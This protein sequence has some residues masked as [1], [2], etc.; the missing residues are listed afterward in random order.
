M[1]HT[2]RTRR[3]LTSCLVVGAFAL[4]A[5]S[6]DGSD[7]SARSESTDTS[8]WTAASDGTDRP[9]RTDAPDDTDD[10]TRGD[11]DGGDPDALD[12]AVAPAGMPQLDDPTV[13]PAVTV[14][15]ATADELQDALDAA[16]PGDV[17][18]LAGGTY[19]GKFV[20]TTSG[21]DDDPIFLCGDRSSVVDGEGIKGG[22]AFH[23]DGAS[24]WRL[25]GFT[26]RNA[27]KG[28]VAD[29]V[30]GDIIEGLL[31]EDIGDEAIHL[32]AFS[33]DNAVRG[34]EIRDTG[35]RR[36]K[37]GE[38]VYVGTAQS[39]WC[40]HSD[41][42]PD[43]SDHN[44]VEGNLIYGTTAESIDLKEGTTGGTVRNNVFGGAALSGADSWVDAKGNDWI[45]E[46]N[47]G[48]DTSMDGFQ[49]HEILEGWG[50]GNIFRGN[51]AQVNGPGYG[52]AA[53]NT[54][55]NI[56]GCDNQVSGADSGDADIDCSG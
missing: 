18:G 29:G 19:E 23:L 48:I 26:V 6:D 30:T 34:N 17:I 10:S 20:A 52:F 51:T 38:G 46:N 55:G 16:Q 22:Y 24:N 32:R 33:S 43:L 39:N 41:C 7:G 1:Q 49:M 45:I 14:R 15:V 53:T 35:L 42:D 56:I 4:V 8:D 11:D 37:F 50:T 54:E 31:V 27:Q 44:L 28:V 47:L 2:D 40:N 13:C 3:L 25:V 36:D 9:D 5:C 21:A 12:H